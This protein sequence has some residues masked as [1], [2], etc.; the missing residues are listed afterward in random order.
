MKVVRPTKAVP[1]MRRESC[2]PERELRI[3][4]GVGSVSGGGSED[5]EVD[6][7]GSEDF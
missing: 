5:F 1:A 3:E 2:L 4:E 7:L 6:M